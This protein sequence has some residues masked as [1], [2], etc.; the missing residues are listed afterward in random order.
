MI[1]K[2]TAEARKFQRS[3]QKVKKIK[4]DDKGKGG[5]RSK[6][7]GKKNFGIKGRQQAEKNK[8]KMMNKHKIGSRK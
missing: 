6:S 1:E 5:D 4:K 8:A 2:Q 7:G 3:M